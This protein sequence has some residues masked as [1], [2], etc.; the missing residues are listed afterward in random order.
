MALTKFRLVNVEGI[1]GLVTQLGTYK[2]ADID[3]N[4]AAHLYG[5]GSRYVEKLPVPAP[6][7]TPAV[8]T[9]KKKSSV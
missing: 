7:P 9:R 8:T 1:G 3:D 2:L 4:I 6:E 5:C